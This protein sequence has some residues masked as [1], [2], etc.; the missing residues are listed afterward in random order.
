LVVADRAKE[1]VREFDAAGHLVRVIGTPGSFNDVVGVAVDPSSGEVWVAD[2]CGIYGFS[3]TGAPLG[4]VYGCS[5]S[6][7]A[8]GRFHPGALSVG[9]DG[10]VYVF[11]R[12]AGQIREYSPQGVLLT[13][14][15]VPGATAT[16]VSPPLVYPVAIAV[17]GA[18]DVYVS[19]SPGG[20]VVR[21][22]SPSGSLRRT[23]PIG[24]P[25][26]LAI[27]GST[28][29]AGVRSGASAEVDAYPLTAPSPSVPESR[30]PVADLA[31]D[32]NALAGLTVG[33][34]G[35]A[36]ITTTHHVELLRL[37]GT[38]AGRWGGLADDDY[39]P[40]AVLPDSAGNMYVLDSADARVI[41][42]DPQGSTASVFADLSAYG[43]PTSAA[44]DPSGDLV[45]DAG[46][47]LVTLRP[48]GRIL[49]TA[50]VTSASV[51]G[52]AF[53]PSGNMYVAN[54]YQLDKYSPDGQLIAS[55]PIPADH[56]ATDAAGN[57]YVD[58]FHGSTSAAPNEISEY[59]SDGRLVAK[60]DALQ[61]WDIGNPAALA[62][63]A[64]RNIFAAV[65]D[66]IREFAPDGRMIAVWPYT[67]WPYSAASI[68]VE[69][70]AVY[71][72][73]QNGHV[74]RFDEFLDP[75][76]PVPPGSASPYQQSM[77]AAFAAYL[78]G[79]QGLTKLA[80]LAATQSGVRAFT[81]TVGCTGPTHARCG[82]RLSL[83]AAIDHAKRSRVRSRTATLGSA[84][85]TIQAG[86]RA[87]IRIALNSTAQRELRRRSSLRAIL[88]ARYRA[89]ASTRTLTKPVTL[90]GRKVNS[91]KRAIPSR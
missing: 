67:S 57:V 89:G 8:S 37:D 75:L 39:V 77:A 33:P 58:F 88:I 91:T 44:F 64:Q 46:S 60:I 25:P 43:Q 70:G 31:S 7:P 12:S 65:G 74:T 4:E 83:G 14:W 56:V 1:S 23:L 28:L 30:F 26:E 5:V 40:T 76:P 42:Y 47:T 79:S 52:L 15:E 72:A 6:G 17:D 22:F 34:S 38:P 87:R 62:V 24:D 32:W 61:N 20:D 80:V 41:R 78:S 48:D 19:A 81:T 86:G 21:E 45:V 35:I 29:Y 9:A 63:D 55:W 69:N 16:S 13:S 10:T 54:W 53:D 90:R 68:N 85:F 66:S 51:G 11:D 18:G 82:G 73:G 50:P 49:K 59:S 71:A 27:S 2:Y 3:T 84:S 36:A